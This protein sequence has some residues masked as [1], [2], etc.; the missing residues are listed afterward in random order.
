MIMHV[1]WAFSNSEMN[2]VFAD[3]GFHLLNTYED[4]SQFGCTY[5]TLF[6][7]QCLDG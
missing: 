5:I 1:S 2:W 3:W 6:R 4:S 7:L